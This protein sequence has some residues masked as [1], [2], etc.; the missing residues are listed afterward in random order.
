METEPV[1]PA[2]GSVPPSVTARRYAEIKA[3][4]VQGA[5]HRAIAR[6]LHLA[7]N[8]VHRYA[9]ATRVPEPGHRPR[10]ISSVQAYL[11]YLQQRRAEN[12]EW[13]AADQSLEKQIP[14]RS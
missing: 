3:L 12:R 11:P 4:Q 10:S 9:K 5:S 8:T 1:A 14:T 6:Q 13:P 2:S 7:R